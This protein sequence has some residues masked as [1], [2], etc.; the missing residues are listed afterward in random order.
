M[1]RWQAVEW[2]PF[3]SRIKPCQCFTHATVG[4]QLFPDL[5]MPERV[6][7]VYYKNAEA[8]LQAKKLMD[9][10]ASNL[11]EDTEFQLPATGSSVATQ[12]I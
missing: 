2:V 6:A 12:G 4:A 5:P 11:L 8:G 3:K 1:P 9:E 10:G 7:T